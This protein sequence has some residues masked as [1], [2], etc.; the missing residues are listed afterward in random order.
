M[1]LCKH[2]GGNW[3][4]EHKGSVCCYVKTTVGADRWNTREAYVAMQT[5]R[6]ELIAGT[7]G[8]RMLLCEHYGG[9]WSLEHKGSVCCYVNTTVGTDRWNTREAY[10]AMWTLRWEL[11]AGTQGKRMLL[12]E[13]CS[14]NWHLEHKGSVC[15][16][17]NTAVGT[18]IWNT[19]EA[20]V[21]MRTLRWELIAGTQGKRMLLCE[22]CSGNWSL[23]HKGSVCCYVNTAMGTD[24]WNTREAYVAMRTLRWELIAGTQGKRMLLCEHYGGNWSLEHKGSVCCYVNATVGTDI[25]NTREAYVAMWTLRWELIAGTRE[26]CWCS[27]QQW[28][29]PRRPWQPKREGALKDHHSISILKYYV[30]CLNY[31]SNGILLC[32]VMKNFAALAIFSEN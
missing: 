30:A 22:H 18:D 28:I 8:K 4:L 31:I 32:E 29:P 2:Y 15:C 27:R 23:E 3:S 25:W 16:Y 12:C 17:V 1:L 20:Y 5:L 9:S 26:C 24:I 7:Q 6:W 21:A 14:G 10:V 19:R 13:H 11:I